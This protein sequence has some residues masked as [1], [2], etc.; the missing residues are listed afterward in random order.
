MTVMSGIDQGENGHIATIVDHPVG[1]PGRNEKA[2]SPVEFALATIDFQNDPALLDQQKFLTVVMEMFF[3]DPARF[4]D[5]FGHTEARPFRLLTIE[6]P[7]H[8]SPV[9]I[10]LLVCHA[11]PLPQYYTILTGK[12]G[13]FAAE[14]HS[15]AFYP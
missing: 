9:I 14:F 4:H 15:P 1:N 7:V 3:A 13:G 6:K 8:P 5:H 11:V 10:L 12:T 2:F